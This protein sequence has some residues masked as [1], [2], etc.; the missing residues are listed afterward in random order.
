MNPFLSI[1]YHCILLT[2]LIIILSIH[3]L[4]SFQR[5]IIFSFQQ[6][7][8]LLS[9][10]FP[11]W[12]VWLQ[13]LSLSLVD[14][15]KHKTGSVLLSGVPNTQFNISEIAIQL[16]N[17][18]S[19]HD[20]KYGFKIYHTCFTGD[21]AIQWLIHHHYAQTKTEASLIGQELVDLGILIPLTSIRTIFKVYPFSIASISRTKEIYINS[22]LITV[23]NSKRHS[24]R[25]SCILQRYWVSFHLSRN[26]FKQHWT[27]ARTLSREGSIWIVLQRTQRSHGPFLPISETTRILLKY[28]L[29]IDWS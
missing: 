9:F 7:P 17:G 20:H 3:H 1:L 26:L 13:T 27:Q 5:M 14:K 11:F 23:M 29:W 12:W 2:I 25:C 24:T 8:F 15:A 22:E 4:Y 18:L 10:S 16:H 19:I 21:E 28:A 6:L